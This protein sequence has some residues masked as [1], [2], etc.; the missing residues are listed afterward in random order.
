M[1]S[2]G[3]SHPDLSENPLNEGSDA[4]DD[5]S[6]D[7]AVKRSS[8]RSCTVSSEREVFHVQ[9]YGLFGFSKQEETLPSNNH[10]LSSQMTQHPSRSATDGKVATQVTFSPEG[11]KKKKKKKAR[12]KKG[13][14]GKKTKKKKKDS[15]KSLDPHKLVLKKRLR[16][17]LASAQ[18]KRRGKHLECSA[19]LFMETFESDPLS[20]DVKFLISEK[21]ILK[22]HLVWS[23]CSE[24][25][26]QTIF[27]SHCTPIDYFISF[28]ETEFKFRLNK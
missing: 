18:W 20:N 24:Q 17:K 4:F 12:R 13:K 1:S 21:K 10:H 11:K 23:I 8:S 25:I 19:C 14:K 3:I 22:L 15:S 9:D 5:A 16:S 26:R 27:V 28:I 6:D 7:F 2:Q